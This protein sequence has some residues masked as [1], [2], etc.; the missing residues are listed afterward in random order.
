MCDINEQQTILDLQKKCIDNLETSIN[1]IKEISLKI[2]EEL[3][4]QNRELE[5]LE[6]V[7]TLATMDI[8]NTEKETKKVTKEYSKCVIC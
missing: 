4:V 8:K 7:T 1:E 6:N 5:N 3:K 2:N